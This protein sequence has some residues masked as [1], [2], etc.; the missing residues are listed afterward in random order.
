[1]LLLCFN[2]QHQHCVVMTLCTNSKDGQVLTWTLKCRTV[3]SITG[4]FQGNWE[5]CFVS[6]THAG[7]LSTFRSL[8]GSS[9]FA[10]YCI[11]HLVAV[12]W[13]PLILGISIRQIASSSTCT[14]ILCYVTASSP[15]CSPSPRKLCCKSKWVQGEKV[16]LFRHN[17]NM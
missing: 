12:T 16:M 7:I 10:N 4:Y 11:C 13:V 1:M 3:V 2:K 5:Y 8:E 14:E 6:Y 17:L 15:G 9:P